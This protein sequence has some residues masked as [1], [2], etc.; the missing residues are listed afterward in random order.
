MPERSNELKGLPGRSPSVWGYHS[1]HAPEVRLATP[2][3]GLA[4]GGAFLIARGC[5]VCLIQHKLFL[6]R[7]FTSWRQCAPEGS[8]CGHLSPED[9][10]LDGKRYYRA[11]PDEN[12]ERSRVRAVLDTLQ[13]L[14]TQFRKHITQYRPNR[15]DPKQGL[16]QTKQG[17]IR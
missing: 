11:F 10:M 3:K 1:I 6:R 2:L 15:L 9:G 16:G 5:V 12:P 4:P 14:E 7:L 17:R 13:E 8:R